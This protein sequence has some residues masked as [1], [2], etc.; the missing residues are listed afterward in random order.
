MDEHREAVEADVKELKQEIGSLKKQLNERMAEY[1]KSLLKTQRKLAYFLIITIHNTTSDTLLRNRP[2]L[3]EKWKMQ[4]LSKA[5]KTRTEVNSSK[6]PMSLAEKF[7]EERY[8]E[9]NSL[10]GTKFI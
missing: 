4:F 1:E 10:I 8:A 5:E 2:D 9:I 7:S 6:D 3:Y